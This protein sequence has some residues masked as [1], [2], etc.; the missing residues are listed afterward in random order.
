MQATSVRTVRPLRN[1]HVTKNILPVLIVTSVLLGACSTVAS[2]SADSAPS[3]APVEEA[4]PVAAATET[5]TDDA[6]TEFIVSEGSEIRFYIFELFRGDP[7]IVEGINTEVTGSVQVDGDA[8]S[9]SPIVADASAFV[10]ERGKAPSPLGGEVGWR[11]EAIDRFILRA[12]EFPEIVFTPDSLDGLEP[13][14]GSLSGIL[15]VKGV[16][17]PVTFDV[18]ITESADGWTVSGTTEVL[19]STF[20]LTLPTVAHVAEVADEVTLEIDLVFAPPTT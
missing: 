18:T 2:P 13:G 7:L 5:S 3:A 6:G 4:A 8:V 19:R 9:L 14:P 1:S 15:E 20:E 10:T 17:A 11:D 12:S 16:S